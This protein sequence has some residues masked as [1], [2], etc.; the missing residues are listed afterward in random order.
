MMSYD[1]AGKVTWVTGATGAIGRAVCRHLTQEGAL[2]AA[3]SRTK[4]EIESLLNDLPGIDNIAVS[5]DTTD[6]TAVQSALST[7]MDCYGRIDILVNST[8][9]PLFKPFLEL[10]DSDWMSVLDA[11][12]LAYVRTCRAALPTMIQQGSG[13]II[14][15]SGRGGHQPGAPSHFAGSCTN[16][17]VNTLTKALALHFGTSGIRANTVAPGPVLSE[18]Y[19]QIAAAN[20][21]IETPGADT[22]PT[23]NPNTIMATPDEIADIVTFLASDRSK[24][25]NGTLQ[26]ADGGATTSI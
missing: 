24:H 11:K 1:L 2:V 3:T 4:A 10:N 7:I 21:R 23:I 5:A 19:D 8:T 18:R 20:D 22:T 6:S 26:Q 9:M 16:G 17:A 25:L 15:I 13:T 14:N 12:L